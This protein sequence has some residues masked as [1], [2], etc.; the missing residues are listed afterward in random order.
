MN[1]SE[2]LWHPNDDLLA[3]YA[4]GVPTDSVR[5]SI[6]AHT[7]KC[8]NCRSALARLVGEP[9]GRIWDRLDA[10]IDAPRVGLIERLLGRLGVRESTARLLVATSTLRTS[11]L[12]AVLLTLLAA[13]AVSVLAPGLATP[14]PF[15]AIAP[16]VPLAGVAAAFGPGID[17]AY[18][19]S[20]A[21][22]YDS[23]RLVLLRA[24]AVLTASAGLIGLVTLLLPAAGLAALAWL[25]P[26][27]ALTATMLALAGW[28]GPV[29]AAVC[30][31]LGWI[32]TV[33]VTLDRNA[34]VLF[35]PIGQVLAALLAVLATLVLLATRRRFDAGRL[36]RNP[37]SHA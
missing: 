12:L 8:A 1:A 29:P 30:V 36:P 34:S 33:A 14:W 10:E 35:T 3:L 32:L 19:R 16:L 11:W 17:P 37:W 4:R 18:E 31:G 9:M 6:E 28:T 13:A 20:L 15:L 22:P 23:F 26:A 27:L 21:T 24:T 7:A 5:W 25:L 2:D